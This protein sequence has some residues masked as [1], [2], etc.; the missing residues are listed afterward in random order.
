MR[1][2][3]IPGFHDLSRSE[4]ILL[5]EELWDEIASDESVPFPASHAQELDRRL[6]QHRANPGRLLSINELR[7]R[8]SA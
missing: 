5:V 2:V 1:V 8:L 3:D 7:D 4:K 6:D